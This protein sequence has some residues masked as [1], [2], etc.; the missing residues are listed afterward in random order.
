[1]SKKNEKNLSEQ[2]KDNAETLQESGTGAENTTVHADA[3][4]DKQ[5]TTEPTKVEESKIVSDVK[6]FN[7]NEY[8]DVTKADTSNHNTITDSNETRGAS[9]TNTEL[10]KENKTKW[11]RPKGL[12]YK[13]RGEKITP[14]QAKIQTINASSGIIDE[15]NKFNSQ[16]LDQKTQNEVS[17]L[18]NG[19]ML[20][21]CIDFIA[22]GVILW[23]LKFVDPKYKQI[24]AAKIKLTKE[25][26]KDLEPL[27]DAVAKQL[28]L[29]ISPMAAFTILITFAYGSKIMAESLDLPETK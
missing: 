11:K 17:A 5:P 6:T 2:N 19:S 1:M 20:L 18:I 14:E 9:E 21:M 24:K 7:D 22:P 23:F 15:A 25:E 16:T 28:L 10:S 8:T 26:K 27:A 13:K 4:G 3:T 12:K 29:N